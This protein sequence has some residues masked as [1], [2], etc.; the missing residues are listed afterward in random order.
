MRRGSR[1]ATSSAS[2]RSR[3]EW[4]RATHG[5]RDGVREGSYHVRD[6]SHTVNG[7]RL[8][9]HPD[10]ER[11]YTSLVT[12]RFR[13]TKY[14]ERNRQQFCCTLGPKQPPRAARLT[15]K[16]REYKARIFR[17]KIRDAN[18]TATYRDSSIL[19]LLTADTTI[20][21]QFGHRL[22]ASFDVSSQDAKQ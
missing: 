17:K 15:R 2:R 5:L 8:D 21:G 22:A 19:R 13:D 16:K 7:T 14:F 18:D 4:T 20:V 11:C 12:D 10:F 9:E 1:R 3:R 6:G